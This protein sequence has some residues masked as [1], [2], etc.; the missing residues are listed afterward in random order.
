MSQKGIIDVTLSMGISILHASDDATVES[1]LNKADVALY[2]AKEK[3]RI[4]LNGR[5]AENTYK[6]RA[7]ILLVLLSIPGPNQNFMRTSFK[8][9]ISTSIATFPRK[10]MIF[11]SR[12][13]ILRSSHRAANI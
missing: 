13:V 8:A 4:V 12:F 3:G 7:L 5:N 2:R 1:V 10:C 11:R 6:L 9:F